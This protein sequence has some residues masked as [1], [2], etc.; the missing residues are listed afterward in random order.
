MV[1]VV[2]VPNA[3]KIYRLI[4][5]NTNVKQNTNTRIIL[6]LDGAIINID[7]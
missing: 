7:G 3:L 1:K 4:T 2:M 5:G 6:K